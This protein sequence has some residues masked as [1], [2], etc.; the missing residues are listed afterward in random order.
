MIM[1]GVPGSTVVGNCAFRGALEMETKSVVSS[2]DPLANK[3][4]TLPESGVNALNSR[5]RAGSLWLAA[6]PAVCPR[7]G[8]GREG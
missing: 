5:F 4:R 6:A 8:R 1:E 3:R 7:E 2:F